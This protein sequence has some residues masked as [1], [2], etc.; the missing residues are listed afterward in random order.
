MLRRAAIAPPQP[1]IGAIGLVII[2]AWLGGP[3]ANAALGP[4]QFKHTGQIGGLGDAPVKAIAAQI[5]HAPAAARISIERIKR[6]RRVIFW[7]RSRHHHLVI[8]EQ[9]GAFFVQIVI[10]DHIERHAARFQPGQDMR[11]GG[12]VAQP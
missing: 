3:G 6:L 11:I 5:H 7:V 4:A 9:C 1:A 12:V 10:R 2:L 8:G